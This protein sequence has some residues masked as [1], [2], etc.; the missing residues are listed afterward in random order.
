MDS[1]ERKMQLLKPLPRPETVQFYGNSGVGK[2]T[3]AY[4]LSM[5]MYEN[6]G[7]TTR[8]ISNDLGG[9]GP[10]ESEGLI[11]AGIVE[12]FNVSGRK[13]LLSDM[14]KLSRGWWPKIVKQEREV[15]QPDG[16][17]VTKIVNVREI[18]EDREALGK[19]GLYFL[20]GSTTTST[21]F[22][23]HI[24]KTKEKI[25]AQDTAGKYEE[26]GEQFGGNSQ[27]HYNIV[28]TEM[29]NLYSAF[30]ALPSPV[31]LVAWT[32]HIGK[33][34]L[35]RSGESCYA[36]Q[37]AGDAKNSEVPSWV[38]DCFHLDDTPE[39]MGED[40]ELIQ[41]KQ[42]RAYYTNHPDR[43]TGVNYLCKSRVG[44]TGVE[45]LKEEFPGGFVPLG[46]ER[47]KSIDSYFSWLEKRRSKNAVDLKKWK[48]GLDNGRIL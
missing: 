36:P 1:R 48:E 31:R 40:G 3:L 32:G 26:E 42:V 12:A 46:L 38:G 13:F 37:L 27:G 24:T 8:V 4:Y 15:E 5:W 19:V 39:V 14:R 25:G 29:H 35:K 21:S 44:P 22:L 41:A 47:G 10:L 45:E 9:W 2:T 20:E 33:G 17:T 23:R 30:G 43:E 16:T 28:Q 7:L 6:F 18:L 34:T 11:E